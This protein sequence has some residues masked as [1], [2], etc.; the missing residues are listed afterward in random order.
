MARP[1]KRANG[2]GA[3]TKVKERRRKPYK[4]MVT[5]GWSDDGK[6]HRILLGYYP[7]L[8]KATVAL[9]QYLDNPY[10]ITAG[11]ITFAEVYEK[12]SAQKYP[13]ISP[14]NVHAYKA[15]YKRCKFL[16][17]KRFKEITV[18]DLQYVV[19]TADC[20]Y[21]TLRK[22]D[23][24]FSQLYAYAMVRMYTDR[25][26]SQYVDIKKFKDK[27]PNKHDRT[28][29]TADQIEK[30]K[31]L[32]NT[33]VAKTVLMLIYSGM[34]VSEFLNLKKSDCHL[35]EQYIEVIA[36]KTDSGIRKVPISHKAMAYW[37]YFLN[38]SDSEYLVSM[39][40]RDSSGNKGSTAYRNTY[41][42]PFMET[43]EFGKRDIHETRHTC[44]TMLAAAEVYD[45]KINRILGHSGKTVAEN[46]Y[47][48]L[49]IKELI[50]AIN[51]I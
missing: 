35:D 4:V 42:K 6:Q 26:Y 18:D 1:M 22:L 30:I 32:D 24:L 12:W 13:T 48:H 27:N 50:E 34:R 10:D 38:K 14:S 49:D 3:I 16:Y 8:D 23:C 2:T 36:A 11:K 46:V 33:D 45:A 19:D 15:A 47:T 43:L 21:P 41:W 7:T 29:F 5:T 25:D 44:A 9:V 37:Q 17:S 20:N 28:A 40:G 39:D 51:M 31:A